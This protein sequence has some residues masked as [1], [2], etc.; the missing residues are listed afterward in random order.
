M[1]EVIFLRTTNNILG[2]AT[3]VDMGDLGGRFGRVGGFL[4]CKKLVLQ[5]LDQRVRALID[6]THI[7]VEG[8]VFEYGDD[9]IVGFIA[10]DHAQ[11][12]DWNGLQQDI[13]VCKRSFGQ[14][15]DIERVA[16]ADDA[17]AAR[18]FGA[19]AGYLLAAVGLWD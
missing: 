6:I 15:A 18:A 5:A 17:I 4:I 7:A 19:E 12:A 9:F 13:A 10:V 1:F 16:V 2:F 3:V 8:V 14:Y 11:A